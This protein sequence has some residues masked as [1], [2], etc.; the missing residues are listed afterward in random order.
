[1]RFDGGAFAEGFFPP[2]LESGRQ[3]LAHLL[4]GMGVQA[5]HPGDLM[6]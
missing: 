1:M 4:R 2:G 3:V 6:S 5:A